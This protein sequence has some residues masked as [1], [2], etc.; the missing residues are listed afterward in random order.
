[1]YHYFTQP[2]PAW[3]SWYAHQFP[4]WLQRV[5]VALMFLIEI[6]A[7]FLIF[8]G[9]RCRLAAFAAFVALQ[10]LIAATGSYGFFNLLTAVLCLSLLDDGHAASVLP[11]AAER[12]LAAPTSRSLRELMRPSPADG[13]RT[14]AAVLIA[15]VSL[16]VT[17]REIVRTAPPGELAPWLRTGLELADRHI[18]QRSRPLVLALAPLR[19]I[20]GYGL[21]RAMT[22]ERPEIAIE[23]R[24]EGGE[25]RELRFRWKPGPTDRRPSFA[26]PHQPRLD[27]QMWFAALSPTSARWL[28]PLSLRLLEGEP[29]V[30][31][32]LDEPVPDRPP[33]QVRL[34]Y[35]RYRFTDRAERSAVGDW[36]HRERVTELSP[37]ISA[38]ELRR[39]IE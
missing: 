2:L 11:L 13:V 1:G 34:V 28:A 25:W 19:S 8:V 14:A 38:A 32:L 23:V 6:V 33:A 3:T 12:R 36:W 10:F 9:R 18:V 24:A 20:N 22:T 5:S 29:A 26:A 35:Y 4:P 7:P 15:T 27:W 21:F 16:A 39:R 37:P 17:A 30:W 31:A